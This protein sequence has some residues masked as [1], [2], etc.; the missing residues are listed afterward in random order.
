MPESPEFIEKLRRGDPATVDQMVKHELPRI[1][2][3][4]LRLSRNP[5]DAEDLAQETFVHAVRSLPNFKGESQLSTWLYR[6]AVNV[7]KNRVRYDRRRAS[8]K[9]VSL[10]G[11]AGDD[12]DEAPLDL[13]GLDRPPEEWVALQSEHQLL[14]QAMTLLDDEDRVVIV[15]RDLEDR[16]YEE[17]ADILKLNLGTLKSRISRAREELREVLRRLGGRVSG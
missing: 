15:L 17:I 1:Y 7:W 4:C 6:I 5:S 14:L 8:G 9:H 12:E 16:P 3:L 13:P 10:S 2:N 11:P